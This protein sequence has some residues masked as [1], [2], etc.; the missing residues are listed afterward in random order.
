ML[1]K[2]VRTLFSSVG[3]EL[4][5]TSHKHNNIPDASFYKPLFSPWLGF[6]E[7]RAFYEDAKPHTLLSPERCYVLYTLAK[8]ALNLS[9]TWYECGIYKGGSARMLA[10]ILQDIGHNR[11][12]LRLFD[13]F[14]GMPQTDLCKDYHRAN[15]FFETS[16]E[17]V[18]KV[19]QSSNP[20][21]PPNIDFRKGLIPETF[22]G[23]ENDR[24]AL[25]HV[26]LDIYRS[27]SDCC[28][29]V[30]PRLLIGGCMV[31]DDYGFP[32]CPGARE[33]VDAYFQQKPEIPLV[34][35]TGQAIIIKLPCD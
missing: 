11:T 2:L 6:G 34:L 28:G 5:R 22:Q 14:T 9:G 26:D 15:Q 35:P 29:F 16:L 21:I 4:R 18:I 20:Q 33:G 3:F 31:F 1:K 27:I 25:C 12:W 10:R 19:V 32:S 17:H 23:L 7:F 13:T 24:I 30:Y 8:Q